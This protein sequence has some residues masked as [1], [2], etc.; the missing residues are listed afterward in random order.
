MHSR[1]ARISILKHEDVIEK[2]YDR[3][4]NDSLDDIIKSLSWPDTQNS[5]KNKIRSLKG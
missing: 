4:V 5:T 2:T 3:S 1:A